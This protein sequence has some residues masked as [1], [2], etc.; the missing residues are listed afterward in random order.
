MDFTKLYS[1]VLE[2]DVALVQLGDRAEKPDH[3][4]RAVRGLDRK[5]Q[6]HVADRYKKRVNDGKDEYRG[7]LNSKLEAI[8]YKKSDR[9][10]LHDSDMDFIVKK[11]GF[12]LDKIKNG[13]PRTISNSHI[14][15]YFDPS[16][17]S[18]CLRDRDA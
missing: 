4:R 13:T 8:R 17:N 1:L 9:E 3:Q 5:K 6:S 11:Y 16:L 2:Y 10:I 7:S 12:D 15:L 18:F 14:L